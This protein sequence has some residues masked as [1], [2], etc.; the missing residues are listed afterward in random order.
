[1]QGLDGRPRIVA[2]S[3]L[4]ATPKGLRVGVGLD[5]QVAFAG[6]TD[7]GWSGLLLIVLGAVSGLLFGQALVA[8]AAWWWP[9]PW[10]AAEGGGGGGGKQ[11]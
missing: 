2:F 10:R 7:A 6:V 11:W 5:R 4:G 8:A 9:G 1:M 3:P